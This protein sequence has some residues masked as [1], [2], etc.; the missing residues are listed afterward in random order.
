MKQKIKLSKPCDFAKLNKSS[1]KKWNAQ[2]E[3]ENLIGNNK[4]FFYIFSK[5][6]KT[7]KKHE[8]KLYS[9]IIYTKSAKM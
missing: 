9:F 5:L 6:R 1:N 8:T 4:G 3:L 2:F 7:A